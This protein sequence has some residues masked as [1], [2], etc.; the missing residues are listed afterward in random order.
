MP[1]TPYLDASVRWKLKSGSIAFREPRTAEVAAQLLDNGLVTEVLGT[2]GAGKEA[3]VF[4]ARDGNRLVVAK[5]YRL[6]RTSN[7][8]RGAVKADGMGHLASREFE[9]L[10][11]AWAHRAPVPEPFQREENAFTMEFVGD[12]DGPAPQ[13][14]R[15]QLDAPADFARELLRGI[16][17]LAH[18]GVV[19]TDLSPFNIL[20]HRGHPVI[21]DLGKGLRVDRLGASPWIRLSEARTALEHALETL[22]RYFARYDVPFET[23]GITAQILRDIDRFGVGTYPE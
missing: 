8:S 2:I 13:L 7:R 15:T 17:D 3:D 5:S 23:E 1:N 18:A 6:Y 19:H 16:D 22:R 14:R 20:V 4:L 12:G 10:G 21:I 11:Y 9:L